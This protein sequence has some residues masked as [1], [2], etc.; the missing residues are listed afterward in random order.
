VTRSLLHHVPHG[1][2]AYA[3]KRVCAQRAR[4]AK[5]N[6]LCMCNCARAQQVCI[7][8]RAAR[9]CVYAAR[10]P[11]G[12][13][14]AAKPRSM[15]ASCADLPAPFRHAV[16]TA[17]TPF[18]GSLALPDGRV[19]AF[20]A[21]GLGFP[22]VFIPGQLNSRLFEPAWGE[23]ESIAKQAGARVLQ[24]DRPGYGASTGP[25]S[26]GYASFGNDVAFLLD[27]LRVESCA[28]MGYSSGGPYA[29]GISA[30]LGSTRV[31]RTCLVAADGPYAHRELE[32]ERLHSYKHAEPL[33]VDQAVEHVTEFVTGLRGLYEKTKD[34]ARRASCLR[35][36][37]EAL[38]NGLEAAA[39]DSVNETN[40][41]DIDL[42]R[43]G[44]AV[45][46]CGSEDHTVLPS[47]S[48]HVMTL[49]NGP[50]QMILIEGE[51]HTLIKR[52]FARILA[53]LGLP[54]TSPS[55]PPQPDAKGKM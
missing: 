3:G 49:V 6:E 42:K 37:D 14:T 20:H 7:H 29:L 13:G 24:I 9:A 35:D 21:Y 45:F 51:N 2:M 28:V 50:A 11:R 12:K 23:S 1:A 32:R 19:L 16:L 33:T 27:S 22:V 36:L 30:V 44:A 46:V 43:V 53:A 17:A 39:Q 54:P 31:H 10:R 5:W 18:L 4:R 55:S 52:H 40:A 15:P 41:W 47:V 34:P 8:T 25:P 26:K 48:E 38:R